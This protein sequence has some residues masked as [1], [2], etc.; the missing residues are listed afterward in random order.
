[1]CDTLAGPEP[2]TVGVG[3]ACGPLGIWALTFQAK[4]SKGQ[5][6]GCIIYTT[7]KST[8]RTHVRLLD[9]DIACDMPGCSETTTAAA[10]CNF[11]RSCWASA[12]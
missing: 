10:F 7:F 5:Q 11:R 12:R 3:A 2:E 4:G 8:T 9:I 1:M 6:D